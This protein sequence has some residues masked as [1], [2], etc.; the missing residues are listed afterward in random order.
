MRSRIARI[1]SGLSERDSAGKG[2]A[3]QDQ[4]DLELVVDPERERAVVQTEL[5]SAEPGADDHVVDV[6][7][8]RDTSPANE[9]NVP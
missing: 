4:P 6:R 5:G 3:E 9:A 8:P 7:T 1:S 2:H